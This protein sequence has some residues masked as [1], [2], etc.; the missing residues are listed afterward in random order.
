MKP[1]ETIY[2]GC[3]FRSRL[4]AKWAVFF[5]AG[6]IKYEYEPEG[7]ELSNGSKY[8]PDFYFPD[9]DW[10]CEVKPPRENAGTEILKAIAFA[11]E[12]K[13]VVL[14]L[15]NI[16]FSKEPNNADVWHYPVMYY[17]Q[18]REE[19]L[20]EYCTILCKYNDNDT[21]ESLEF[22]T[23]LGVDRRLSM[24]NYTFSNFFET[25]SLPVNDY[26]MGYLFSKSYSASAMGSKEKDYLERV[27]TKARQARFEHGEAP[28]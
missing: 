7:F 26:V 9:Y 19:V 14:V 27:Y 10:Y 11:E 8:L 4:E 22:A 5:D 15:S 16:P 17:N 25:H 3:R 23:W 2:N 28:K 20:V 12:S 1:I 18:L 6:G 21:I 24:S 13:K